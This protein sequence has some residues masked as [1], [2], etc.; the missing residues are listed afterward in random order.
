MRWQQGG[1]VHGW[2]LHDDDDDGDDESEKK[3]TKQKHY[4]NNNDANFTPAVY[5]LVTAAATN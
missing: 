3:K 1:G 2:R 5:E 4:N